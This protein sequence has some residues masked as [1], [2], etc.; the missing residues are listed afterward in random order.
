MKK[1]ITGNWVKQAKHACKNSCYLRALPLKSAGHN[2]FQQTRS[3]K[4]SQ[5]VGKWLDDKSRHG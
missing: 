4:L 2:T 3:K 5:V 1:N